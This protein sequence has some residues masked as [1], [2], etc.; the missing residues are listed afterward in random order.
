MPTVTF[1]PRMYELPSVPGC[2]ECQRERT[3]EATR[4]CLEGPEEGLGGR[5]VLARRHMNPNG[6]LG[7]WVAETAFVDSHSYVDYDAN[8]QDDAYVRGSYLSEFCRVTRSSEI[9]RSYLRRNV[10]TTGTAYVHG[11]E[12]APHARLTTHDVIIG[13][14][15]EPRPPRRTCSRCRRGL[16]LNRENYSWSEARQRFNTYCRQCAREYA[17]QYRA[18]GR[19]LLRRRRNAGETNATIPP[20]VRN[21][22]VELEFHGD[23]RE[24]EREMVALGLDCEVQSYNHNVSRSLWKIVP[25]GSVDNGAELV[26]PILSGERGFE[27]LRKASQA[28]QAAGCSVT[29]DTGFHVHH[30]VRDLTAVQFKRFCMLWRN[31]QAAIDLLVSP[32][33]RH[34]SYCSPLTDRDISTINGLATMSQYVAGEHL[35]NIDRFKSLNVQAFG[36]YGTVEIRQHQGTTNAG[37]ICGWVAFGQAM[38]AYAR[39]NDTM[40]DLDDVPA[41]ESVCQLLGNLSLEEATRTFLTE[42]AAYFRST[43]HNDPEEEDG[44]GRRDSYA[45]S[46]DDEGSYDGDDYDPEPLLTF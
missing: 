22:G 43:S 20:S 29:I 16:L 31:S 23:S 17:Q 7:G 4:V 36:Q 44:E 42:R 46:W 32:S 37:K 28:L 18:S 14:G 24:L 45:D 26:S 35:R 3:Q 5:Q 38:I 1:P 21:F 41:Y 6:H 15:T 13:Q 33:R 12:I 8:V 39:D 11:S 30:E 34:N 9:I 25:D 19:E 2:G 10:T 40:P 27:A